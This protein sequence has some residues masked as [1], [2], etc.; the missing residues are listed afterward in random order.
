MLTDVLLEHRWLMPAV[1][2]VLVVLGPPVGA[3]VADRRRTLAVLAAA[4]TVAVLVLT[5]LPTPRGPGEVGR[6]EL[7]LVLP[8]PDR[9]ELF[10]NLVLFVVPAFLAVLAFRRP[11]HALVGLV[12][13]SIAIEAFQSLVPSIGRSCALTDLT[14]NGLGVV[15]GVALGAV[16]LRIAPRRRTTSAPGQ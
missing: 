13:L 12:L 8:T 7:T 3:V 9:V 2:A 14:S 4:S 11:L 10:G 6:C 1:L 15:I 5:L 16:A